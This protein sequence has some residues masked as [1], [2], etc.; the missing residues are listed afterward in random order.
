MVGTGTEAQ[1]RADHSI[2]GKRQRWLRASVVMEVQSTELPPDK[3]K[4]EWT[5]SAEAL[6]VSGGGERGQG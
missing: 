4:A 1:L 2:L 3:L 5:G 6:S